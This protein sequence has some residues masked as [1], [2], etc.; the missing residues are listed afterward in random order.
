MDHNIT[1]QLIKS[2][3]AIKEKVKQMKD[4]EFNTD[5]HLKYFFKPLADPL[6]AIVANNQISTIKNENSYDDQIKHTD[7]GSKIFLR[8]KSHV[9]YKHES[10][11]ESSSPE[12]FYSED[13][14]DNESENNTSLNKEDIIEIY[15]DMNIPFG[16]RS[17]NNKHM[18]GNTIVNFSTTYE[19]SGKVY[20]ICVANKQYK[21]TPGLRELLLRKK[22]A[23]S[24]VTLKDKMVYKDILLTTNAHKRDFNP[25]GQIKGDKGLKYLQVIKPLFFETYNSLQEPTE[26]KSKQKRGAGL[27][28][29]KKYKKNTELVYWD[30]P[31]ELVDRL[32]LLIASKTAGNTNLDNEILS[33]IE[34]LKEAGVIQE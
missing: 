9:I 1:D 22:P 32:K 16:V 31:N 28:Y 5:T 33:I 10:S 27:P 19:N 30:D 3:D 14:G 34:E 4:Y 26:M 12:K 25:A 21:M 6:N 8:D 24:L 11:N 13:E 7:I 20:N 18:I 17:D 2:A 29:L 15:E 23:L